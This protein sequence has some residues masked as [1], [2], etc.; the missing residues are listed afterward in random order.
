MEHRMSNRLRKCEYLPCRC[1]IEGD[2]VFCSAY[3]AKQKD[4]GGNAECGCAHADCDQSI[5]EGVPGM[6]PA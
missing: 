2:D 4:D 6:V 3:C 5:V 1:L